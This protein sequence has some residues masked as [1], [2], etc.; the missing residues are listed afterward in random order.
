MNFP[1]NFSSLHTS[2]NLSS[3]YSLKSKHNSSIPKFSIELLSEIVG[4]SKSKE[5]V[6]RD[7]DLHGTGS[8]TLM[9]ATGIVFDFSFDRGGSLGL[10]TRGGFVKCG[11]GLVALGE[12]DV[13]LDDRGD[14]VPCIVE[15][16]TIEGLD[17]LGGC[18]GTIE[19][20][21]T[22]GGCVGSV[23]GLDDLGECVGETL[24]S[25]IW[26]D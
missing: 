9:A 12:C 22:L 11:V 23:E 19:G 25:L 6:G 20:L 4:S 24:V 17:A 1:S 21:D 16:D 13:G 18:L 7:L 8:L 3:L 26:R 10:E 2:A 15:L 5:S 14:C